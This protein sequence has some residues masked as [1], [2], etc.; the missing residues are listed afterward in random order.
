MKKHTGLKYCVDEWERVASISPKSAKDATIGGDSDS[1]IFSQS[2]FHDALRVLKLSDA[3]AHV[4]EFGCGPGRMTEFLAHSFRTV[5][6]VDASTAMIALAYERL[7]KHSSADTVFL[8]DNGVSGELETVEDWC[9]D[10][11]RPTLVVSNYVFLHHQHEDVEAILARLVRLVADRCLFVIQ[12]PCYGKLARPRRF[13]DVGRVDETTL[14][15]IAARVGLE[16]DHLAI[17][18]TDGPTNPLHPNHSEFH[19]LRK[20]PKG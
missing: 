17:C 2:G 11:D 4:L 15:A 8:V 20:G 16:V 3:R 14:R 7:R 10:H 13:D 6:A 1:V 9:E 18:P 5:T 12:W 19:V